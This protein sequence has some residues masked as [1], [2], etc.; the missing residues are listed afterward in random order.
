MLIRDL[1][2]LDPKA[3]FRN[4]VQ[5]SDYD[6]PQKNLGL[7]HSYLFSSAVPRTALGT[8]DD[9][10]VAPTDVLNRLVNAFLDGRENRWTLIANYGHGKSH[11]ALALANY[12][13]KAPGT[14]EQN[15]LQDKL[16]QTFQNDPA[17]AKRFRDFKDNHHQFIVIRVRGDESRNLRDQFPAALNRA[18]GEHP[19]TRN[20]RPPFWFSK[21]EEWLNN[22]ESSQIIQCNQFLE[23]YEIDVPALKDAVRK[24]ED[25]FYEI[26][27]DLFTHLNRIAPDFGGHVNLSDLLLWAVES[28]CGEGKPF[29]GCLILFDEFNLYLQKYARNGNAGELQ[30]LLQGVSDLAG[31]KVVFLAFAP[32]DPKQIVNNTYGGGGD[33]AESVLK[34]LERLPGQMSLATVLESVIAA[35][36]QQNNEHWQTLQQKT[37]GA[38]PNA[39]NAALT[40]FKERY[41]NTLRWNEVRFDEIVTR[42]CFPL[43]PITT[44]LLCTLNFSES[45]VHLDTPR[46][47]LG[48]IRQQ[49][50][51]R[52]EE[53][54][55]LEPAPDKNFQLPNWILPVF[56][57]DFFGESIAQKTYPMYTNAVRNLGADSSTEESTLLKGLLLFEAFIETQSSFANRPRL[58]TRNQVEI[59]AQ[60]TGLPESITRKTLEELEKRSVVRKDQ[61]LYS[62]WSTSTDPQKLDRYIKTNLPKL[63][64]TWDILRTLAEEYLSQAIQVSEVDWGHPDDWSAPQY[65]MT[66]ETLT[67]GTLRNIAGYYS[68]KQSNA[69][70]VFIWLLWQNTEQQVPLRHQAQKVLDE[71]FPENYPLPVVMFLTQKSSAPLLDLFKR[72]ILIR[73]LTD[74]QKKELGK[75]LVESEQA[76]LMQR[77]IEEI[78]AIDIDPKRF[79][80]P[81]PSQD[82]IV[83]KPYRAN[84]QLENQR[85]INSA[86]AVCYR[87]AYAHAPKKFLTEHKESGSKIR[88]AINFVSELL[89]QNKLSTSQDT[90]NT[91]ARGMEKNLCQKT[92]LQGW[93]I[94]TNDYLIQPP[95]QAAVQQ[96]WQLFEDTVVPGGGEYP[97][98]PLLEKLLNP[99][100]GYEYRTLVLLLSAWVGY[101]LRDLNISAKGKL[102]SHPQFRDFLATTKKPEDFL[103]KIVT[104]Q[105]H[106][107][108]RDKSAVRQEIIEIMQ[109]LERTAPN[110]LSQEQSREYLDK[111]SAFMQDDSNEL[112]LRQD[113]ERS[114]TQLQNW[115][116]Q[117]M[118][119]DER[120]T[121]INTQLGRARVL[122]EALAALRDIEKLPQETPVK[123]QTAAPAALRQQAQQRIAEL[124][125]KACRQYGVLRKLTD[126]SL[127]QK[128]LDELH[129]A[130]SRA[131]QPQ[132]L[133]QIEAS[134]QQLVAAANE[135]KLR[136]DEQRLVA[137]IENLSARGDLAMLRE[138]LKRL[139]AIPS[140][141]ERLR[142]AHQKKTQAIQSTI[143]GLLNSLAQLAQQVQNLVNRQGL[144]SWKEKA[145]GL[146]TQLD[147]TPEAQQLQELLTQVDDIEKLLAQL[148]KIEQSKPDSREKATQLYRQLQQLEKEYPQ[149]QSLVQSSQKRFTEK[150]NSRQAETAAYLTACEQQLH[151]ADAETILKIK[152]GLVSTQLFLSPQL[153][154]RYDALTQ[155]I[156]TKLDQNH[157]LSIETKFRSLSNRETQQ[158]CLRRLEQILQENSPS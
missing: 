66:T 55:L 116:T 158:A 33:L 54:A 135:L 23:K 46:N 91:K 13:A 70:G 97:I 79:T 86:L 6:D 133:P 73:N 71:A 112:L 106:F 31:R 68:T 75:E 139:Q 44:A 130:L 114:H 60:M 72:R 2:K 122:D 7:L 78:E 98:A 119:Y 149:Q 93:G 121:S 94:L 118:I 17:K 144:Q 50:T 14:P 143:Q 100:Y 39:S 110:E 48:F 107:A 11:L 40:L 151:T 109:T 5:I 58:Q 56:L 124:V 85:S 61:E 95:T 125:E 52:S 92:L 154:Q 15:I 117:A 47:A 18:L 77:C 22:L 150:I 115:L 102:I 29:A 69:R 74:S 89:L 3:E 16:R 37:R 155:A 20:E 26:C 140:T 64:L 57:V 138:N 83:P 96:A 156:Q 137:Q 59:L 45:T 113:A 38:L 84:I 24:G 42:G 19:A 103:D 21:A 28:F 111:L 88:T 34:E 27:R 99:P 76:R 126:L 120:A 4:D 127:H 43:H 12:F 65:W 63:S 32:S 146:K 82:F 147:S 67:V 10:L 30:N 148:E 134:Q 142:D 8:R 157:L 132:Y 87:L 123:R 105:V 35:Y 153:Q 128:E 81:F 90:L 62:F 141:S 145:Y 36:L 1:V 108:L 129:Q 25:K 51:S 104:E 53:P 41:E 80:Q 136:E 9:R 131:G 101:H 49:L 152:D